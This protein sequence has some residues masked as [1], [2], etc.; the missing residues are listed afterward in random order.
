VVCFVAARRPPKYAV[1]LDR[2]NFDIIFM[3]IMETYII[4]VGCTEFLN[5]LN[6]SHTADILDLTGQ[7]VNQVP[8]HKSKEK[9]IL[10]SRTSFKNF[11]CSC[12]KKEINVM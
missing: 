1:Y 11:F 2:L 7:S 6:I 3:S 8:V 4:S 5:N 12:G 9:K 10:V